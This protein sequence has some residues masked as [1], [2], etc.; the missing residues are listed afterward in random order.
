MRRELCLAGA[1]ERRRAEL[2]IA[3]ELRVGV[4]LLV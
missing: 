3:A 2:G 4:L 1:L